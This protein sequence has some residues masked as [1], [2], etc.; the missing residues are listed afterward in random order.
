MAK[1]TFT[2]GQTLT[3][4]QMNDLQSNDFNLTVSTKTADYTFVVG[5]R[6]TR[7]VA[8]SGSAIIFTVPNSVFTAG[9]TFAVHSIGAGTLTISAGAGVTLN[10]ADVLTVSQYQGGQIFFTTA[11]SAI[12]FPTAKTVSVSAGG[13]VLVSA[14]TIGSGVSSVAVSSAFSSTYDNYLITLSG[15]VASGNVDLSLQLGATTTGYYAGYNKVTYSTGSASA[16]SNNNAANFS[17][18]GVGTTNSLHAFVNVLSPNLA[19]NTNINGG[20]GVNLAGAASSVFAGFLNDSTQYT[21]FTIAPSS[22]TLTGGTIRVYGYA[23]S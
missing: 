6:G 7:V 10:G 8:N 4:T 19:K 2:A 12:F 17:A 9:D 13:V 20:F 18:I 21:A 11:S 3:A 5:D 22:G 16:S 15:G 1:Q 23:N 14:T